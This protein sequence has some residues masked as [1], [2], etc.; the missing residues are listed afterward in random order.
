[1]VR[2]LPD[3]ENPPAIETA[4]GVRFASI[5]GWNVFHYGLLLQEFREDYP[6]QEL[7]PPVGNVTIQIP[8]GEGDFSGVPVRCWFINKSSTELVQVQNDSFVRN[9]RKTKQSPE[10]LH[11]EFI[12]P[13]FEHDWSKFRKF[14]R[15]FNLPQPNVFQCE[16]TYVNQFVRG[17][18]WND[19][20]DLSGLYR[21]WSGGRLSPLLERTQMVTFGALYALPDDFGTLQFI[22]QPAVRKEDGAEIIQL[23]VTALGKPRSSED[24]DILAWLDGGRAA[25]V[26]GFTDFT[27]ETAHSVWRKK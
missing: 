15:D 25:V 17:I 9:W 7:R 10:Y 2:T 16:V 27:S 22:S 8:T 1:M 23:T 14:L 26:Q 19:F 20:N 24:S 5:A 12:R 13:R 4:V 21:V 11:Y 6:V 3:F 18:E